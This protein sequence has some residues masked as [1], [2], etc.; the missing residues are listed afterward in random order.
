MSKPTLY[1][2]KVNEDEAVIRIH[3]YEIN[4]YNYAEKHEFRKEYSFPGKAIDSTYRTF[5]VNR[6]NIDK[7]VLQR[8]FTFNPEYKYAVAII[9]NK[10]KDQ[11]ERSE[12]YITNWKERLTKLD[13]YA[14]EKLDGYS[15]D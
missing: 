7:Y 6:D 1:C 15:E 8:V 11:I 4:D 3:R 9:K 5:I 10:L 2:F 13:K 12:H 14:K